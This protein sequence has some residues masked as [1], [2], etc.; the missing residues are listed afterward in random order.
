[1]PDVPPSP[2][3]SPAAFR[4]NDLHVDPALGL[5]TGP[6]GST[7]LEPRVLAVLQALARQPGT[8]VS[9]KDLLSEIWPGADIYDEAL[10]QCVYQLRQQLVVAGGADCRSLI[11]TVPKRGYLLNAEVHAV[12]SPMVDTAEGSLAP[13]RRRR[14]LI[15]VLSAALTLGVAWAIFEWL[16]GTDAGNTVPPA[17]TVAVLPFLPL[18]EENRDPVLELGMADT[19]IARLSGIRQI[20]VRPISSVRQYAEMDRDALHAGRELGA[21]AVVEGSIQRSQQGLR[22][23]V[24]LLRVTDGSA[25]WAD[26]FH[27]ESA[28]LFAVQDAI[29]ERIAT[30]LA[31]EF[32]QQLQ[33]KPA[34]LGTSDVEAYESY[35]EGRYVLARLTPRDMRASIDHFRKAVSLDPNYAQAWLGLA[36]VQFRLPIAGEAPPWEYFPNAKAAALKA[37][38][39]DPT[40][41]EGHAMLG[42]IAHWYEWDWLASETHFKQAIELDPN[43]T[44]AHLGYAHLLSV[45]GR[46]EPALAEV[47]RAREIS[48]FYPVATSLEGS[49]LTQAGR[50]EEAIQRLEEARQ[51]YQH[52]WLIRLHLAEAYMAVGRNEDALTEAQAARQISGGGTM[53][54]AR[55]VACL[56]RL[57]RIAES[58]ALFGELLQRSAER[59]VPPYD[60]ALAY[61]GLGNADE[62]LTWLERAY[63]VRDPKMALLAV[64]DWSSLRHR[65]EFTDLMRRLQL[66]E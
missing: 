17:R 9:R 31:R 1:M 58:E 32:G 14:Y 33:P 29:C 46:H 4:I 36:N 42:W 2:R 57:G 23:S 19:L 15:G 41:A 51:Q 3:V 65:P 53:A 59:Y 54:T 52:F 45:T 21:E 18:L 27:E 34:R 66:A 37:L 39:I 63:E 12:T 40:L 30:A 6:A 16:G 47:R 13:P 64:H 61:A 55:E 43:D 48:P 38:E 26:T 10:T 20:V 62:A 7:R 35:L 60:L 28:S 49:F 50:P 5:I 44:E 8:L 22:V 24:R 25:L 56:A 11:S